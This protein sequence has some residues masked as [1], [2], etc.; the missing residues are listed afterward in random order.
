M[1]VAFAEVSPDFRFCINTRRY[2]SAVFTASGGIR[3]CYA[4]G[5]YA[6]RVGMGAA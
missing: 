4:G 5:V 1:G 6:R 2:R 3:Y